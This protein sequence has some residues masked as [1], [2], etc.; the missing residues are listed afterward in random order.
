MIGFSL[1]ILRRNCV[2][3]RLDAFTFVLARGER[4]R[5]VTNFE[6]VGWLENSVYTT[7]GQGVLLPVVQASSSAAHESTCCHSMTLIILS[8]SRV[9]VIQKQHQDKVSLP[10]STEISI[11]W[12]F[13]RVHVAERRR[14][15]RQYRAIIHYQR[16]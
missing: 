14:L 1:L 5:E 3:C 12:T 15:E 2:T 16:P 9:T 11:T 6:A 4:V 13:H 10:A 8:P 7:C